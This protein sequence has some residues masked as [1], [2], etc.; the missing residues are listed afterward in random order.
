MS[1]LSTV[2]RQ[3][4]F[5]GEPLEV[6]GSVMNSSYVFKDEQWLKTFLSYMEEMKEAC[7]WTYNLTKSSPILDDLVAVWDI[8][9]KF[10]RQLFERLPT[11]QQLLTRNQSQNCMERHLHNSSV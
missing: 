1:V 8:K 3:G 9:R 11:S 4:H 7:K 2:L 6:F 5:D 10:P